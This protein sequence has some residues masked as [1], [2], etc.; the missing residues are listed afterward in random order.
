MDG[1]VQGA[2]A[3]R[4][5]GTGKVNMGHPSRTTDSVAKPGTSSGVALAAEGVALCVLLAAAEKALRT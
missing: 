4:R 3:P 2:H 5:A 1:M